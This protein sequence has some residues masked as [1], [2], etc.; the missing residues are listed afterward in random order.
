MVQPLAKDFPAPGGP[1]LVIID[2]LDE[3]TRV[4]SG[5]RTQNA[6]AQLV[7]EQWQYVP[8]WLRLFITSRPESELL[9]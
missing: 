6:I 8:S 5:G 3:V 4:D 2:A 1:R 9:D 7:H